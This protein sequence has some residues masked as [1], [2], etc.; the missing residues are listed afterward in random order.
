MALH[1]HQSSLE[2]VLDFST[3]F[4][5]NSQQRQRATTLLR[6]LVQ[7]YGVEQTIR[8]RFK[9]ASLIQ[10]TFEHIEAQDAFLSFYFSF[11]YENL[12]P[13]VTDSTE[14]AFQRGDNLLAYLFKAQISRTSPFDPRK[15]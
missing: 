3:P 7:L 6:S 2:R 12:C 5:L 1:R 14:L 13:G 8:R 9:P 15:P 10:L 4:S 11:L